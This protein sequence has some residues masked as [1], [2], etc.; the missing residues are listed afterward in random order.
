MIK[1]TDLYIGGQPWSGVIRDIEPEALELTDEVIPT[2]AELSGSFSAELTL[3]PEQQEQMRRVVETANA[4]YETVKELLDRVIQ[5][6]RPIWER[7]CEMYRQAE[8][9]IV[10]NVS[11]LMDSLLYAA[12]DNPKWWHYHKHAKKW[13]TR[14]KYRNMLMRQL[15]GKLVAGASA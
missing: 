11:N 14:K 5:A 1:T 2:N 6:V 13:R 3:T 12:N 15:V 9:Q 7:V 10:I 4:V 8:G